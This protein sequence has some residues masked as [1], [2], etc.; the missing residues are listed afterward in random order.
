MK[1][2]P[3][4]HLMLL[5]S[6]CF[7]SYSKASEHVLL[8][9]RSTADIPVANFDTQNVRYQFFSPDSAFGSLLNRYPV[10]IFQP[11]FP[12]ISKLNHANA[13]PLSCVYRIEIQGATAKLL[14]EINLLKSSLVHSAFLVEDPVLLND[15]NDY[16]LTGADFI[17]TIVNSQHLELINARSAWKIS[18]GNREIVIGIPDKGFDITHEDVQR[19]VLK[20]IATPNP[21]FYHGTQVAHLAAGATGNQLGFA[22]IGYKCSMRWYDMTYNGL[23]RAAMD[24]CQVINCSWIGNCYYVPYYQELINLIYD[25][26]HCVIVAAAGN[27]QN[28]GNCGEAG[29]A[30]VYPAAYDHVIA[31]SSVGHLYD[32]GTITSGS[33]MNIRDQH[34]MYAE[35]PQ[36]SHTHNDKVDL[37]AP[38]YTVPIVY[39]NNKYGYGY[40]TSFAAPIVSGLA[41]LILSVNPNIPPNDVE[42]ILKCSARDL[43]EMPVNMPYAGK[44]GAGRIDAAAAL[45]LALHWPQSIPGKD[46]I[47]P[48]NISWYG[49]TSKGRYE[50]IQEGTCMTR[51]FSYPALRLVA[52]DVPQH[53]PL[54]WAVNYR[55][56]L[57]SVYHRIRYSSNVNFIDLVKGIDYHTTGNNRQLITAVRANVCVSGNYYSETANACSNV[58]RS[59]SEDETDPN[60]RESKWQISPNPASKQV[61]IKTGKMNRLMPGAHYEV[62]DAAKRVV[63]KGPIGNSIFSI[64]TDRYPP[65]IYFICLINGRQYLVEKLS[66]IH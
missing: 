19:K 27:G 4:Q 3:F 39:P 49:I 51:A 22:S 12:G 65:G 8:R 56:G 37:C 58:S 44:L 16:Q 24:G 11:E 61:W 9:F 63:A 57:Q 50:P 29:N 62:M 14:Q 25:T 59:F 2:T 15:P 64:A 45:E 41:A 66:V 53:T 28:G 21:A 52:T 17:G 35:L 13:M 20:D 6:L 31:V 1:K 5:L 23:L 54:K 38:G 36:Y 26:Y 55:E 34:D 33:R 30:Y 43:L 60:S 47:S 10:R 46:P 42:R 32:E 40:G 18:A 48:V 7:S